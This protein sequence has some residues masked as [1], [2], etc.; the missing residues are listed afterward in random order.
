MK[1]ILFTV[2]AII[3]ASTL[4]CQISI[5]RTDVVE[6]NDEI[7][8]IYYAYEQDTEFCDL[9]SIISDPLIFDDL[10]FPFIDID[11]L[12]Y[13]DP[14]ETDTAGI[15]EGATCSYFTRDGFIMHLLITDEQMSVVGV[16]G[17]LPMSGDPMNLVFVDTLV[18]RSFPCSFQDLHADVGCAYENQ[19]ISVFES[20]IPPDYYS[21]MT[22]LYDT[23]KFLMDFDVDVEYDQ[24]GSMQC[25]GDSN[26]NGS[27][28]YLR[29]KKKLVTVMDVQLRSKFSGNYT[30]L[31]DIPGI[32]DQLPME[33]PMIDT[34]CTYEY[35]TKDNKSPL[36]EIELNTSFDSVHSVTYRYAYLSSVPQE[37]N[38]NCN[39]Y[40]NPVIDK[41]NFDVENYKECTLEIYSLDGKLIIS[42]KFESQNYSLNT[43]NFAH[44]HYLYKLIDKS[45]RPVAGGKF[46]KR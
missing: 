31:G 43:S 21:T 19:H 1:K 17:E 38:L 37:F 40:P 25:V 20:I 10:D 45:K 39:V 22:T 41:V 6:I 28:Q 30:S 18:L 16:Q 4:Y 35:W 29:E 27:F 24:Y 12:V 9:D 15:F 42:D 34:A 3:I 8:R 23:V 2:F 32:G 46:V 14:Q 13:Q 11:T 36:T 33:L 5:V 26:L 7:P 44:G